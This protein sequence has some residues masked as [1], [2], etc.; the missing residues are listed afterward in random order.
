MHRKANK[1]SNLNFTEIETFSTT[2][3]RKRTIHQKNI[4]TAT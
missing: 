4:Y 1:R 2:E 3:A